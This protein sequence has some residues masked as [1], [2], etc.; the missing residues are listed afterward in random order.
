MMGIRLFCG[1]LLWVSFDS[2]ASL[3]IDYM[4]ILAV[5]IAYFVQVVAVCCSVLQCAVCCSV[6]Q[7][8]AV[9]SSVLQRGAVC[10]SVV[11][12]GAVC[13][14]VLTFENAS[15]LLRL[16]RKLQVVAVCGSVADWCG[17][18]QYVAAC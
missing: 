18:L 1:S 7:C 11:Q 12:C 4:T 2:C 5:F 14:S 9:C 15:R 16:V 10:C 3:V 6:L 13:Y 17:V 8:V